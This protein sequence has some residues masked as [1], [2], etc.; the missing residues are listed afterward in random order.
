VLDCPARDTIPEMPFKTTQQFRAP[1]SALCFGLGP[2]MASK[3]KRNIEL[4]YRPN[5]KTT[6]DLGPSSLAT[7]GVLSSLS[8]VLSDASS[9]STS[10]VGAPSGRTHKLLLDEQTIWCYT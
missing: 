9:P 7:S 5:I 8:N 3:S 6:I 4:Q 10:S 2:Q 1:E